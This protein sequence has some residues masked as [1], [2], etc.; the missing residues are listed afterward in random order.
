MSAG[1]DKFGA[2]YIEVDS[3]INI[4]DIAIL[5]QRR[6]SV[7]VFYVLKLCYLWILDSLPQVD[8]NLVSHG[9]CI[10]SLKCR[11]SLG[12]HSNQEVKD[13][14]H[15]RLSFG[16]LLYQSHQW[17]CLAVNKIRSFSCA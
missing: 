3:N 13:T 9:R 14:L 17:L 11:H 2:T 12:I 7:T 10:H 8:E 15:Y 6:L 5:P 16:A 1:I 4:D